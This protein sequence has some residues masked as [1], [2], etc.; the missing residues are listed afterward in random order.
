MTLCPHF[1]NPP[2]RT[3]LLSPTFWHFAMFFSLPLLFHVLRNFVFACCGKLCTAVLFVWFC[4][5]AYSF[6]F[7]SSSFSCQPFAVKWTSH[8]ASSRASPDLVP[9]STRRQPLALPSPMCD[10]LMFPRWV[11]SPNPSTLTSTADTTLSTRNGE[12]VLWV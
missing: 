10:Q 7:A 5:C 6:F 4:F 11:N 3:M 12:E 9:L 8:T 2:K 1:I